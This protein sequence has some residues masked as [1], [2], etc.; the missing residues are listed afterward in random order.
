MNIILIPFFFI[1]IFLC[2][3]SFLS[4]H[5]RYPYPRAEIS[6]ILNN[7]EERT[8]IIRITKIGIVLLQDHIH[9]LLRLLLLPQPGIPDL[10][11]QIDPPHF[12]LLLLPLRL[13]G[14]THNKI[15]RAYLERR[16]KFIPVTTTLWT[17]SIQTIAAITIHTAMIFPKRKQ[18]P[19]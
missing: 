15:H 19:T 5:Q 12:L 6:H 14:N 7:R 8:P 3:I 2:S 11:M 4:T 18:S 16:T 17:R 1:S 9:L 10:P 13:V